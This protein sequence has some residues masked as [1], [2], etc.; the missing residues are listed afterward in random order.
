MKM[1]VKFIHIKSGSGYN[2]TL[3]SP[4]DEHVLAEMKHIVLSRIANI[5]AS[6][7]SPEPH[8]L[9]DVV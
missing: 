7:T 3:A 2:G 1:K 4:E 8:P 6:E 9:L 5:E